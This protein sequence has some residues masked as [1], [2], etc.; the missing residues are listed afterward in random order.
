MSLTIDP[1][2]LNSASPW[3]TTLSDLRSLY[4]CPYT[5][6]ITTRTSLL[7][8]FPHDEAVNQ[9]TFFDPA[10][11]LP[12]SSTATSVSDSKGSVG[13]LNTLGYSPFPLDTYISFIRD[14]SDEAMRSNGD[15]R[16]DKLIIISVTGSFEEVRKCYILIAA[17]QLEVCMPLAM[18]LNLSCPNIPGKPPPAYHRETLSE[19]FAHLVVD[20]YDDRV[21][22]GIKTPPY[23]HA[24]QFG[25]LI[26]ALVGYKPGLVNFITATNTLA[27]S[28]VLD[29]EGE[30]ALSSASGTGMG[31]MAG[32]PLHPLAL[33]NVRSIRMGLDQH[34]NLRD[35]Q[36]IGVGG[37]GDRA[38]FDRMR[39]VGAAAVGVGTA[40]GMH[41]VGVFE[42]IAESKSIK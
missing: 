25:E 15:M 30:A 1:P 32:A 38:G 35:V 21:P 36:I 14:L 29:V 26:A 3:A 7:E 13:S 33:G 28:L 22:L 20:K 31:G 2:L 24:G 19:Y 34:E 18:E 12:V 16:T 11:S 41:G 40:L 6:A 42:S 17:L 5:G 39:K 10:T 4:A 37:V 9:Y 8:G 23:T 27:P